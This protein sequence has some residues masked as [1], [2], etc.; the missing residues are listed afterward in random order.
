MQQGLK[1][2]VEVPC[3]LA[4]KVNN[5]WSSLKM[6]AHH[7]NLACKSDL[8]VQPHTQELPRPAGSHAILTGALRLPSS[9]L[10]HTGFSIAA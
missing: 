4:V 8:Q 6:L 1:T 7:G 3:T 2:A 10:V 5:L 9:L